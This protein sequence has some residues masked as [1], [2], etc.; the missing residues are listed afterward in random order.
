MSDCLFIPP[1][2]QGPCS[3]EAPLLTP[4]CPSP[5]SAGSPFISMINGSRGLQGCG[6]TPGANGADGAPGVG[7][8]GADGDNGGPGA[9]GKKGK[10]GC[11]AGNGICKQA[12][13]R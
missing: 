10:G 3:T 4:A 5:K 11:A 12:I 9:S 8:P 7:I 2:I 13:F 1:L 6:G